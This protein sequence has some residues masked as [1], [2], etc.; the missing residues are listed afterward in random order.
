LAITRCGCGQAPIL[1]QIVAACTL[2][3]GGKLLLG[4]LLGDQYDQSDRIS[5]SS[6]RS[7]TPSKSV[8]RIN[9]VPRA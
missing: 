9:P 7:E 6:T 3:F 2:I 5:I 8:V 4:G 1:R